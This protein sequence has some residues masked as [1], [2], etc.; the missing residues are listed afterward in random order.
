MGH[1]LCRQHIPLRPDLG[2][3]VPVLRPIMTRFLPDHPDRHLSG[4]TAGSFNTHTPYFIAF[5][6]FYLPPASWLTFTL[7]YSDHAGVQLQPVQ[8]SRHVSQQTIRCTVVAGGVRRHPPG[9]RRLA[10]RAARVPRRWRCIG[11][12]DRTPARHPARTGIFT[13]APD[14]RLLQSLP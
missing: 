11:A 13:V 1:T 2:Q 7:Y 3:P 8:L 4:I 6:A 5:P 10:G 9:R 12:A 14:A